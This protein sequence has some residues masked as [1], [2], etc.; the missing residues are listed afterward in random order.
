M[1]RTIA[2][3]DKPRTCEDCGRGLEFESPADEFG[4]T[5]GI[6]Y[7]SR[8]HVRCPECGTPFDVTHLPAVFKNGRTGEKNVVLGGACYRFAIVIDCGK[9]I[10]EKEN[11]NM[12]PSL[13]RIC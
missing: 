4:A 6:F 11:V 1:H 9:C 8:L 10:P 2:P 3:F 5:C 12:S 13:K 7:S